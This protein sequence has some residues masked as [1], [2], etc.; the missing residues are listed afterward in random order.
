MAHGT[1]DGNDEYE[2]EYWDDYSGPNTLNDTG[3]EADEPV[4]CVGGHA[5]CSNNCNYTN[6]SAVYPQAPDF[7]SD[8][9]WIDCEPGQS[10]TDGYLSW[11]EYGEEIT[12]QNSCGQSC[13][14]DVTG[15]YYS[16]YSSEYYWWCSTGGFEEVANAPKH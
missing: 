12:G 3:E 8:T 5:T 13:W 11:T 16:G 10:C 15:W 6:P 1:C 4:A 2:L 14:D 9:E 7:S